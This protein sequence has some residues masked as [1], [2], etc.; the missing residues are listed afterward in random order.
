[1]DTRRSPRR[2]F[3]LVELLVV[4]AIIGVLIA[5]LLPAIQ[6]AREAARRNQCLSQ[7][8]QLALAIANYESARKV[9]PLA[10]T[11][12]YLQPTAGRNYG[13]PPIMFP[14]P[15]DPSQ[16]GD[17]YS[18]IVQIMGN[19]ELT[20]L[21]DQL[22]QAG[23]TGPTAR[24]GNLRDGAF[25]TANAPVVQTAS[26]QNVAIW[27]T[28]H[29]S[30]RCPSWP[31]PP[32]LSALGSVP[33]FP[34]EVVVGTG[35]YV[36]L[37]STHYQDASGTYLESSS[38]PPTPPAMPVTCA[39]GVGPYC[40][41]GA[42]PFPGIFASAVTKRGLKINQISDGTAY[43]VLIS[44]TRSGESGA[45]GDVSSWY[46]GKA[47]YAVAHW[48][49]SVAQPVPILV[50]ATATSPAMWSSSFPA[51]NRGHNTDT[52]LYYMQTGPHGAP[53]RWGP[54]SRHDRVVVHGFADAHAD[55][56]RDDISGDTY[57]R[58]VT[59]AGREITQAE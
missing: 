50:P 24:R 46:S 49:N 4:I 9:F 31:G 13:S 17:G 15:V 11:A 25:D 40:G 42:M 6:A 47:A 51:I 56:I 29:D 32:T 54:S 19:M 53:L 57:L 39:N 5:L 12:A 10:S 45:I 33:A 26:G 20:S 48:P 21:S 44:E 41:N 38:N 14:F 18:W 55:T 43:T 30:F 34:M 37:A 35:T 2:A 16:T 23:G 28:T 1:M 3:T 59:R 8:R 58:W 7:V 27:G 22:A 52:T 36:T